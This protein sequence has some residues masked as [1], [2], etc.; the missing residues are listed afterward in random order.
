MVMRGWQ[1]TLRREGATEKQRSYLRLLY[2]QCFAKHI[3]VG[4]DT[5]KALNGLWTVTDASA[6]IARLKAL[7]A[8]V[9]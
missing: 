6:E 2:N 4:Y 3:T 7:L 5:G 8:E 9:K 1:R